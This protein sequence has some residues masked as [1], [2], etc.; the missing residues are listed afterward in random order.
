MANFELFQQKIYYKY[1]RKYIR[2]IN[3]IFR[4]LKNDFK[5]S[6]KLAW[7]NATNQ[8]LLFSLFENIFEKSNVT[9][10]ISITEFLYYIRNGIRVIRII[11]YKYLIIEYSKN[12]LKSFVYRREWNN[13]IIEYLAKK[14]ND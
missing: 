5:F 2:R 10:R 3:Y 14:L 7:N 6:N 11:I 4:I 8:I 13:S 12:Q 1:M 9:I